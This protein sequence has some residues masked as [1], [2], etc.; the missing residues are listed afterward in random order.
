MKTKKPNA[1]LVW[2]QI[3]DMVVPRL[4][5]PPIDRAVYSHL[6]RHSRL[7]GIGRICF[8]IPWVARGTCLSYG[9]A[10][11]AVRRLVARGV[12]R[13]VERSCN[14][15]HVV[16]V[17]LPDEIRGVWRREAKARTSARLPRTISIEDIDFLRTRALRRAIHERERG[18]C[19][20][21]LRRVPARVRCLDHVVPRAL[22]GN[23]SYCNLVSCCLR[24]NA[25]KR[26]SRA[27]DFLLRL[28]RE[29]RLTDTELPERLRALEALAAGK[30]PPPLASID[31][32]LP[33][34]G[35][36]PLHPERS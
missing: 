12:L 28:Y 11:E 10:R 18:L 17:L 31:N 30:F 4:P 2:K 16:D 32:P 21:C 24:C 20:Y 26:D 25:E 6:L 35:R 9:A 15:G 1:E 7:E 5:L 13:L 27:Q 8:S 19:F 14:A 34:K 29:R 3:E 23:N 22:L 36:P 33:R